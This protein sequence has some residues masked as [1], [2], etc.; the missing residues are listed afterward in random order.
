MAKSQIESFYTQGSGFANDNSKYDNISEATVY[1]SKSGFTGW[2]MESYMTRINYS[3]KHKYSFT[4]TGR[5]DG[6][7]RFGSDNK[8]AFSPLGHLRGE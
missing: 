4:F 5:F 1:T 2:Q 7:S 8:Y 3:F 6:S